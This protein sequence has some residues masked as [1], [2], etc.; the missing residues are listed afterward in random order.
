MEFRKVRALRGPNIWAQFPVLEAWVDLQELN[1][2]TTHILPGF[3]DR[4]LAWLPTLNERVRG[5]Y[6]RDGVCECL[7][8]GTHMAHI[9][10]RV[11]V[12]LQD[13]VGIPEGFSIVSETAEAGVYKVIVE[14]KDEIVSRACLDAAFRLLKAAVHD[15]PFAIAAEV[16]RLRT[17]A[18]D[19]IPKPG[20]RAIMAAAVARD[21]PVR[22]LDQS[23]FLVLGHGFKQ[24]RVAG[25]QTDRTSAVAAAVLEDAELMR[26]MLEAMGVPV[27]ALRSVADADEAWAAAQ[28]LGLPVIVRP[29]K[30]SSG[31]GVSANLSTRD[32]VVAAFEDASN[33]CRPDVVIEK[34]LGGRRHRL[35]VAN[36]KLVAAA[37][38]ETTR[39]LGNRSPQVSENV[40]TAMSKIA[41]DPARLADQGYTAESNTS[42]GVRFSP[43]RPLEFAEARFA[44][45]ALET[46]HPGIAARAVEAARVVGLDVAVVHVVATDLTRP[47][48]EQGGA[49]VS[50]VSGRD[51]TPHLRSAGPW[52]KAG[53]AIVEALFPPG[54]D[55]RIPTAAVTGVNGK[56]TVTRLIAQIFRCTGKTVGMGCTDGVYVNERRIVTADCSG[57]WSA[58][59]VLLNPVVEVAV[60]E[61][62]RG[63]ILREGLGYERADAVVITNIGEG[64]HL[65]IDDIM[66]AKR[67][68]H[69][70]STLLCVV[71]DTGHTVL[72]AADPLVVG[73]ARSIN[74]GKIYYFARDAANP[75]IVAHRKNGGRATFVRDNAV[76][77]A[78]GGREQTLISLDRV[79]STLGGAIGFQVENVLAAVAATDSMGVSHGAIRTALVSFES[80]MDENPT[81]FNVLE[82][83]GATVILDF[84]HNPSSMVAVVEAVERFPNASRL[85]C[86]SADGDRTDESILSQAVLIGE[87]FDRVILYEEPVRFR[88]RPRGETFACLRRGLEGAKRAKEIIEID[89]EIAAI[90]LTFRTLRPGEFAL[91]QIDNVEAGIERVKT[92]LA[93]PAASHRGEVRMG[94]FR[95]HRT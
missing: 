70:K 82:L 94:E 9:L 89:G 59:S 43:G 28:E 63:G 77:M 40:I 11:T 48:E 46:V 68:A 21:I 10:E 87:H 22:K 25:T 56:T 72:N 23:D 80:T 41:I 73:M 44:V 51:L 16:A 52:R 66:T 15:T 47:L 65:G 91:I 71:P 7:R 84:G 30:V 26:G 45:N 54:E 57:P 88:G 19:A 39:V 3:D 81:R 33:T 62:A 76:V 83:N 90:D 29:A 64:D 49:I 14:Y 60:L 8:E 67:M 5:Q 24:R 6:S 58:R 79:P 55:G 34:S 31:P 2:S 13:F 32:Q 18:A 12:V 61:T 95:G 53:E 36:G 20:T 69:V 17:M 50:L 35:V 74:H 85:I 38:V 75:V 42:T 27:P 1:G 86:Y 92:L 4:L 78:A 37:S 93:E